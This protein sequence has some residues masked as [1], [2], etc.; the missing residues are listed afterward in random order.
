M[1]VKELMTTEVGFCSWQDNLAKAASIMW[2]RDCGIVPVVN[3]ELKVIGLVSDRDICL[4]VAT[5]GQEASEIKT[6]DFIKGQI[7][8]C[9]ADDKI[10][11]VLKKMRKKQV[12][13]LPVT[14]Q[15]GKLIGIISIADVLLSKA[16][17]SVKKDILKTVKAISRPRPILLREID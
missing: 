11:D 13:R 1:K 9:Q 17:Q 12:K 7:V 6:R 8:S 5:R 16:N 4:A 2:E 14:S 15:D 3:S 10:K